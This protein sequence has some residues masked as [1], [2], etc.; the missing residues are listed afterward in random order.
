MRRSQ[1]SQNDNETI[2]HFFP[3]TIQCGNNL[4][5][6]REIIYEFISSAITKNYTQKKGFN[7]PL[8]DQV[9]FIFFTEFSLFPSKSTLHFFFFNCGVRYC[10]KYIHKFGV[11]LSWF[12][13]FMNKIPILE[14]KLYEQ[15]FLGGEVWYNVVY[16]WSTMD[17]SS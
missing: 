2:S 15:I 3:H 5:K 4:V 17:G 7:I 13:I 12:T 14:C 8:K 6:H 10:L 9:N 11:I 1:Y 16:G